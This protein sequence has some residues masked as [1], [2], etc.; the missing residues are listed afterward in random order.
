M[1]DGGQTRGVG[2]VM[3]LGTGQP[4]ALV[5]WEERDAGQVIQWLSP[6]K[7]LTRNPRILIGEPQ[8]GP[9]KQ[10]GHIQRARID[11]AVP[12]PP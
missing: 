6:L 1:W 11:P 7:D 10:E 8:I 3:D 5:E 9:K 4:V 2:V 12:S